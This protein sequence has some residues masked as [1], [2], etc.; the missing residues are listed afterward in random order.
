MLSQTDDAN[1]LDLCQG[2]GKAVSFITNTGSKLCLS[3]ELHSL[4]QIP[5]VAK[6]KLEGNPNELNNLD[7]KNVGFRNSLKFHLLPMSTKKTKVQLEV[8]STR[9][10]HGIFLP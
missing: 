9:K 7:N 10:Y 5:V 1:T 8:K 2:W 6:S 4:V 3:S